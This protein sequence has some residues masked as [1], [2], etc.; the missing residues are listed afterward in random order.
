LKGDGGTT[1][2]CFSVHNAT[3]MDSPLA[4]IHP[5]GLVGAQ[6]GPRVTEITPAPG[7]TPPAKAKKISCAPGMLSTVRK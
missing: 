7:P 2:P 5:V 6:A 4:G 1:V 3:K